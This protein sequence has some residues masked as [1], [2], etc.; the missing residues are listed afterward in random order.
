M[1][2]G[3]VHK[4]TQFMVFPGGDSNMDRQTLLELASDSAKGYR[5]FIESLH[6]GHVGGFADYLGNRL[7]PPTGQ[8]LEVI[9]LVYAL[10][11]QVPDDEL[12][13]ALRSLRELQKQMIEIDGKIVE[14]ASAFVGIPALE[15]SGDRRLLNRRLRRIVTG[16]PDGHYQGPVWAMNQGYKDI[17][18]ESEEVMR[19]A[20]EAK[21]QF[22]ARLAVVLS[23][24]DDIES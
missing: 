8:Q 9:E 16:W 22:D 18:R 21:R 3:H 13:A 2:C 19:A 7:K 15:T 10:E 12:R 1:I 20:E 11:D 24:G 17:L 5:S 6:H 14:W 4:E 23:S